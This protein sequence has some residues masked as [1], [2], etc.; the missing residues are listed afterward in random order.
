MRYSTGYVRKQRGK[1][2]GAWY[3]NGKRTSKT[4]G[5]CK[6]LTKS[7]AKEKLAALIKESRQTGEVT[8]FG[9]FVEGPYFSFYTRKWKHSTRDK[10]V[11]RVRAHLVR[12]FEPRELASFKRD[13][14]QDFLDS[15]AQ[16]S[17]SL[18]NKLRFDLKQIFDMAIAEGILRLNPALLLFCPKEAKRP[19]R[20]VLTLEQIGALLQALDFR[21]RLIAKLCV[22]AGMRPGEVF[23]LR[24]GSIGATFLEVRERVYEGVL[25]TPKSDRGRRDGALAQGVIAD[26]AEWKKIAVNTNETAFVF[27]SERNTPLSSHNVWQR[28]MQPKLKAVGLEWATFQVM[29]R[30]FVS[31]CKAGGGDP[32]AIADQCGHDIGVSVNVY[33]QSS[34]DSKLELVNRLERSLVK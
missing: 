4:L 17:S 29:R 20:R 14:L 30:T 32:K 11:I 25:D 7:D 33:T 27:P 24:W 10:N 1:F 31:L 22:L 26:I 5:L 16:F 9:S 2:I 21:E 12:A 13:E 3:I 8:L 18:V 28:N 19:N 6:D 15:K 34:L 23:A